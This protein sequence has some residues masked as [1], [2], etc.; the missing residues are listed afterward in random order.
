M[1]RSGGWGQ[2]AQNPG[3]LTMPT[4]AITAASAAAPLAV[5]LATTFAIGPPVYLNDV[6]WADYK[7][8]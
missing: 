5:A 1:T 6:V 8:K 2:Y 7:G 3:R 4:R